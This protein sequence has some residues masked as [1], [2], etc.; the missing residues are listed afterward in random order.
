MIPWF[1]KDHAEGN[2]LNEHYN[3]DRYNRQSKN[4]WELV[5]GFHSIPVVRPPGAA[6]EF[7]DFRIFDQTTTS[8]SRTILGRFA[9]DSA[10]ENQITSQI[11]EFQ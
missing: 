6:L 2:K 5:L 9:N 10:H 4:R 11:I 1:L 8:A 7:R 3:L